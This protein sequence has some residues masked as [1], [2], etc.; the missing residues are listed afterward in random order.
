MDDDTMMTA[1]KAKVEAANK[2]KDGYVQL[3]E[4]ME[5]VRNQ[6]AKMERKYDE[7]YQTVKAKEHSTSRTNVVTSMQADNMVRFESIDDA[8][9]SMKTT[10]DTAPVVQV[11]E[12]KEVQE[13]TKTSSTKL[14]Y[15]VDLEKMEN[16]PFV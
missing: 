9:V 10:E 5:Q 2:V 15:D 7:L 4:K 16:N 14:A 1:S 3:A 13:V 8:P 6:V 11:R 12:E